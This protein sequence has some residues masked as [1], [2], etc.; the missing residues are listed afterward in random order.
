MKAESSPAS[1]AHLLDF[2]DFSLLFHKSERPTELIEPFDE[3]TAFQHHSAEFKLSSALHKLISYK[4]KPSFSGNSSEFIEYCDLWR[5]LAIRLANMKEQSSA[6]C[7]LR[8]GI[9]AA[10]NGALGWILSI[11][12]RSSDLGQDYIK[13][14]LLCLRITLQHLGTIA[15]LGGKEKVLLRTNIDTAA[16]LLRHFSEA[17]VR[18]SGLNQSNAPEYIALEDMH[19]IFQ[20][21]KYSIY[22]APDMKKVNAFLQA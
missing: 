18:L 1:G 19:V 12:R 16:R 6:R 7:L 21:W 17:F 14:L 10:L 2:I 22:G 20:V 3:K 4:V 9:L 15:R 5:E 8:V 13:P 11:V